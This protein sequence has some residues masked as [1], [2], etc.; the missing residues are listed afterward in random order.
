M[1]SNE[2]NL[3]QERSRIVRWARDAWGVDQPINLTTEMFVRGV[4]VVYLAAFSSLA[5][6]VL[7]F[8]GAAGL[9]STADW[10]ARARSSGR[11][12]W[13]APSLFWWIHSDTF[14][15]GCGWGGVIMA[16]LVVLGLGARWIL[17]I[18]WLLYLSFV[19]VGAPFFPFQWDALLLEAG[20]LAC[21]AAWSRPPSLVVL[22]LIRWLAFRLML[23]NGLVKLFAIDVDYRDGTTSVWRDGTALAYHYFTQ[24]LPTPIA[25]YCHQLPAEVHWV[26]TYATLVIEL[27]LPWLMFI[28]RRS[29]IAVAI[30]FALVHGLILV[31]GSHA[32]YNWL[33]LVIF[34]SLL[35]DAVF[36]SRWLSWLGETLH[37]SVTERP[38]WRTTLFAIG[39]TL[40]VAWSFFMSWATLTR[41]IPS[42]SQDVAGVLMPWYLCGGYGAFGHM[43]RERRE[44]IFEASDDGIAWKEYGLAYKPGDPARAPIIA[45]PHHPRL[46]WQ[47]WFVPLGQPAPW[48]NGVAEGLLRHRPETLAL[49]PQNPFAG[50][51][52]KYIRISLYDYRFTSPQE[53]QENH[54][55]WK[56]RFLRHLAVLTLGVDGKL[57]LVATHDF[58]KG[59]VRRTPP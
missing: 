41:K 54:A 14:L 22:W 26:S 15:E 8:F 30:G 1:P 53:A 56:R 32:F 45:A 10:V 25:W 9:I 20:F 31:T 37:H 59:P 11:S 28:G 34:V 23:L 57:R 24:P 4:G 42:W 2:A 7:L 40:L 47:L 16:G 19:Q 44:L 29:R 48:L 36:P 12:P 5:S 35:D 43:T 6:Q 13:E 27:G 33:S 50:H 17:P 38:M 21:L 55:W 18:L 51:P 58:D 39:A 49:F 3:P 52:P 46:D